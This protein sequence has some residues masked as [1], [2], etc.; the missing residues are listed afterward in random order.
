MDV[1]VTGGTGFIGRQLVSHLLARGDRIR[2]LTRRP[3]ALPGFPDS[4]KVFAGDLACGDVDLRPF[5]ADVDVLF[6][7]AGEI[8]DARHMRA[9][10]VAGT[11]RLIQAASGKIGH[12]VQLSSTGAY[13]KVRTGVV[14]EESAVAPENE[15]E[16]T[17]TD[18]DALVSAAAGPAT[19]SATILRPSNVFG[20]TMSN[21]S[22]FQMIAMISRGI[23][24]F[25][26][27]PGVSANYIDV[28]NVVEAM[29]GC[30][31]LPQARGQTF[32]LSDHR[33]LEDFVAAIAHSLGRPAPRLRVPE[34]FARM[35]A[36]IFRAMPGFPLTA[37]RVDALTDRVVYSAQHIG[38]TLNYVY[39][40]SMEDGVDRVVQSWRQRQ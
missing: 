25:M 12:W 37:S 8:R 21:R 19:F 24:F 27:P 29:L 40:V 3:A 33:S 38:R 7:C 17:K 4:V 5:V 16:R 36:A 11:E 34:Q 6:H 10:H 22:L 18:S 30:A 1:A 13:G 35:I 9:L 23:Y 2:L 32:I 26:G 31:T 39:S 15:Y 28:D 20:P 14:T